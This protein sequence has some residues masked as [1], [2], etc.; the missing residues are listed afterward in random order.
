MQTNESSDRRM[1]LTLDRRKVMQMAMGDRELLNRLVEL[2]REY[3]PNLLADLE[4]AVDAKDASQITELAHRLKGSVGTFHAQSA[5]DAARELE[6]C[7]RNNDL[8][9]VESRL[10]LLTE[11]LANLDRAIHDWMVEMNA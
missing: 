5:I 4:R 9:Q 6:L 2:F 7:G 8:T 11:Q 3:Y 1:P 10:R